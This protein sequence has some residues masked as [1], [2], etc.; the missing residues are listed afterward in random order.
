MAVRGAGVDSLALEGSSAETSEVR[1]GARFVQKDQPGRVKARLPLPPEPARP[2]DVW[3][4]LLAGA[5]CLF[6]YVNPIFANTTL[7]ACKEHSSP[8]A[9]RNSFKVRSLFLASKARIWLW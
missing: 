9:W 4:V 7:I 6:L 3:P 1:L 2:G 8:V 5:E